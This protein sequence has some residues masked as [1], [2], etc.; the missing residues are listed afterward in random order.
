MTPA[1]NSAANLDLASLSPDHP[2]AQLLTKF[3]TSFK[4]RDFKGMVECYHP[5]VEFGDALFDLR[6][7]A[8]A[9]M[10]YMLCKNATDLQVKL[11]DV[12]A[13][14]RQGIAHWEAT[15]NFSETGRAVHNIVEATFEFKDGRII[16]HQD[17]WDFW[18]WSHMAL[19]MMGR[20]LGWTPLIRGVL[21]KKAGQRLV[22]FI[23]KHREKEVPD[24]KIPD[25]PKD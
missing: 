4:N 18:R 17:D 21:K 1:S 23:E 11:V 16:K 7:D 3:Y 14:D 5:E 13:N 20:L 9:G 22:E 6:G 10:W 24:Y 12:T 2:N 15:Y 8:A 25:L 19:G